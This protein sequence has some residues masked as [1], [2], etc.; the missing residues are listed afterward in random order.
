MK[1]RQLLINL[2][3]A[4]ALGLVFYTSSLLIG[5][6]TSGKQDT[7]SED[8]QLADRYLD[9]QNWLDASRHLLRMSETDPYN[10]YAFYN[11]A[12]CFYSLR[13]NVKRQID[14]VK[15]AQS[16]DV[17]LDLM[18]SLEDSYRNFDELCLNSFQR[19]AQ[20]LRYRR[21]ALLNLAMLSV[22]REE[23]EQAIYN[24]EQFVD[25]GFFT[26]RGLDEFRSLG[27]GGRQVIDDDTNPIS[28]TRLHYFE[29]FWDVVEKEVELRGFTLS[30]LQVPMQ[31]RD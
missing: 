14:Q 1:I 13:Q 7:F 30:P 31:H 9:Q 4:V 24:L 20:F 25:E 6:F 2:V 16:A 27:R 21:L 10:G 5:N 3:V 8:R 29:R 11:L 17:D 12:V 15:E 26:S 19:A 18:E 22:E 28:E 23:W